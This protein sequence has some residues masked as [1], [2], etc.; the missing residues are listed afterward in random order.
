[1]WHRHDPQRLDG[2]KAFRFADMFLQT[3]ASEHEG[4]QHGQR[5][6]D[7]DPS[8]TPLQEAAA[9]GGQLHPQGHR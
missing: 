8:D 2:N 3:W 4:H 5:P 9:L 7:A 1:M 6:T